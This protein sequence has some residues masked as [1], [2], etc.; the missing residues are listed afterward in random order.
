MQ[1]TIRP[2]VIPISIT[3]VYS[4]QEKQKKKRHYGSTCT[5]LNTT[6]PNQ[7]ELEALDTNWDLR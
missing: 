6:Q 3:S 5:S 1:S 4:I 7:F 2:T